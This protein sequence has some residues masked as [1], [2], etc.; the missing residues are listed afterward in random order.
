MS[1]AIHEKPP[2]VGHIT[3]VVAELQ[4]VDGAVTLVD[5]EN[6]SSELI[7]F[8]GPSN[9]TRTNKFKSGFSKVWGK[10]FKPH[11]DGDVDGDGRSD[12]GNAR[13][14][15]SQTP[16]PNSAQF[17]GEKKRGTI[18]PRYILGALLVGG[19][20][21]NL[22]SRDDS[23]ELDTESTNSV[24][25][26]ESGP[27]RE[28]TQQDFPSQTP[29]QIEIGDIV[30]STV[31]PLIRGGNVVSEMRCVVL[32]IDP[33]QITPTDN[34]KEHFFRTNEEHFTNYGTAVGLNPF[35]L[36]AAVLRDLDFSLADVRTVP[37][38]SGLSTM[39]EYVSNV[40]DVTTDVICE[41]I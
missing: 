22:C 36:S 21:L 3:R 4:V 5:V 27:V 41:G 32:G 15:N 9:S 33:E 1:E 24:A 34:P 38:L 6:A 13:F 17:I 20:I 14:N 28:T 11:I 16:T 31:H 7:M 39:G 2:V 29:S 12:N 30:D 26:P 35:D 18:S 25:P 40:D 10:M 23:D 8:D 37:V 19:L